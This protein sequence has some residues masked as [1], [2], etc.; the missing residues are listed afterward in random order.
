MR[1]YK[2]LN[3][4]LELGNVRVRVLR[5]RMRMRMH[6]SPQAHKRIRIRKANPNVL[7]NYYVVY[8]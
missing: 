3:E 4:G 5:M 8:L 7:S 6:T 2:E 1:L